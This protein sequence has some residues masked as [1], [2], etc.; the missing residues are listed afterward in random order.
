MRKPALM[1]LALGG[2]L[3]A[4]AL[5]MPGR[6]AHACGWESGTA[7]DDTGQGSAN[8][9]RWMLGRVVAA[10][11]ADEPE[12]LDQ[13]TYG[14][15]GFRTQDLYVFCIGPDGRV[16]AHPDPKLL[17]QDARALHD[18]TGKAFAA[19]MLDVAKEGQVAEVSYLYPRPGSDVPVPKV[20]FVTRVKDQVCGVGNYDVSTAM[21]GA[22]GAEGDQPITA[23]M[24]EEARLAQLRQ[25]LD[26]AMPTNL[27]P[28][29]TAFLQALDRER[30][31]E[32]AALARAREGVRAAEMT[33][34]GGNA[35]SAISAR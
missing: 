12:A 28:D 31:A 34:G 27:R 13:F 10:V 26:A 8:E 35:G 7:C 4:A 1:T 16:S 18:P 20:S 6:P 29:W 17:G 21:T 3:C 25:R 24:P 23:R 30:G 14:R 19:E 32:Q 5:V 2:A 11:K 9:A 33:L 15:G 22:A